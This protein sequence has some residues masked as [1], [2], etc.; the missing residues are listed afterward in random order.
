M[1]NEFTRG[2]TH[3]SDFFLFVSFP[4]TL[5]GFLSSL[6][7][8]YV[9]CLRLPVSI[10]IVLIIKDEVERATNH[11]LDRVSTLPFKFDRLLPPSLRSR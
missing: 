7:V 3:G 6:S 8:S 5:L 10:L 1:E 4:L 9:S 11:M 2:H